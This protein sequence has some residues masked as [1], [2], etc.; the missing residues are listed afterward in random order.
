MNRIDD[1]HAGDALHL[2]AD[3]QNGDGKTVT[4]RV[5]TTDG[6]ELQKLTATVEDG[7]ARAT[8]LVDA[9]GRRLPLQLT[10]LASVADH[11][12]EAAALRL[13]LPESPG[14]A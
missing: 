5:V 13:V 3:V 11:T 6:D 9:N 10:L 7:V 8:W 1:V 14:V 2:V 12:V 4:F